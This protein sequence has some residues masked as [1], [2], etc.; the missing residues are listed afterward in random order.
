MKTER[1]FRVMALLLCGWLSTGGVMAQDLSASLKQEQNNDD[2]MWQMMRQMLVDFGYSNKVA[3]LDTVWQKTT[4]PQQWAAAKRVNQ[5]VK[6]ALVPPE[7]EQLLASL[8]LRPAAGF[9]RL[10]TYACAQSR[11][12]P[13]IV[14]VLV[15]WIARG[16]QAEL[17]GR[18]NWTIHFIYGA[19]CELHLGLGYFAAVMKETYDKAHGEDFSFDDMAA[20]MAGA[21]WVHRVELNPQWLAEWKTGRLTLTKNLPPLCYGPGDYSM[22]VAER[23]HADILAAFGIRDEAP[24]TEKLLAAIYPH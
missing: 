6:L 1:W 5:P 15:A 3:S 12:L 2:R 8:P 13:E 16:G 9:S 17:Q 10:F 14:R 18:G 4:T 21:E 22:Q 23:V 19:A 11:D 20:S 7:A 24:Q